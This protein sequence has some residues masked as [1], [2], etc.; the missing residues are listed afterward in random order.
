LSDEAMAVLNI[1][2]MDPRQLAAE[3]EAVDAA[4]RAA[5]GT[6]TGTAAPQLQLT[7]LEV[8]TRALPSV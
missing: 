1:L 4:A 2:V 3:L 5:A 7:E 6:A 8:T